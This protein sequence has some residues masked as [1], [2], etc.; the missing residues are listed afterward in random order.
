MMLSATNTKV[1]IA[2]T[3]NGWAPAVSPDGSRIAFARDDE[4]GLRAV[5]AIVATGGGDVWLLDDSLGDYSYLAWRADGKSVLAERWADSW[6]TSGIVALPV[7]AG[8]YSSWSEVVR[9]GWHDDMEPAWAELDL[10]APVVTV[11]PPPATTVASSVTFSYRA[12]DRLGVKSYDVRYRKA[13]YRGSYSA[14]ISPASWS[15]TTA[16]SLKPS[17]APGYEY[18]FSVRARDT[19]GN[20]SS[21]TADRCVSSP[22]DDR[23]LARSGSWSR[24]TGSGHYRSTVTQT[25]SRSVSLTRSGVQTR[26][27]TLVVTKCPTCGSL[28]VYWGKT[29]I[30]TVGLYSSTTKRRQ[31]V[32]LRLLTKVSSGTLTIRST[33]SG[34]RV[35]V[36]GVAFRRT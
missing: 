6:N 14:Y 21:W 22:L 9:N 11:T 36:D 24:L 3:T 17:V 2:G 7:V 29:K 19:V 25:T 26:R 1:P 33:S 18:C 5:P 27:I 4:S 15:A 35:M 23:S 16:T 20:V 8:M 13:S 10:A 28:A 32:P 31:L 12:T 30:A 34:R